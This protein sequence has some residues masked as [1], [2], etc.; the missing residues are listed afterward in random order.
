MPILVYHFTHIRNLPGMVQAGMVQC[1]TRMRQGDGPM[2]DIGHA[3]IKDRRDK[4]EVPVPPFGTVADYVPFYFTTRSPM[5]YAI[6]GGRVPGYQGQD[7]LIYLVARA[8]EIE[9]VRAC[10]FTDGNAAHSISRFHYNLEDSDPRLDWEVLQARQ[11]ANTPDDSDRKR[12][13]QAEFLVHDHVPLDLFKGVAVRT[14]AMEQRV[15]D[16]FPAVP[17]LASRPEWY[18]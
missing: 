3:H 5:L 17:F 6:N 10:C 14:P 13:R 4:I 7:D 18:Y 8:H 12:R 2:V 9:T 11:W 1:N 16:A 15:R